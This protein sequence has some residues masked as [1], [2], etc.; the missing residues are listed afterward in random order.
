VAFFTIVAFV[1]MT[2][3]AR[4]KHRGYLKEFRDYPTLRASILPFVL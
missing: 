2:I 3:W 1:Q 4:G